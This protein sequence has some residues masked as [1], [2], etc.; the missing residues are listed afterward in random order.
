MPER[1]NRGLDEQL[2]V[3]VAQAAPKPVAPYG[4]GTETAGQ[5][6]VTA[7][8]NPDR[9][10]S[11]A[12]FSMLCGVSPRQVSSG[13]TKRHRLNRGGDRQ[14]KAAPYRIALIRMRWEE[15][16]QAYVA[17]VLRN[18]LLG[19][20]DRHGLREPSPLD[21]VFVVHGARQCEELE[22]ARSWFA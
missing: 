20:I 5:L 13:K 21:D 12:A 4:V 11:E 19:M 22:I 3:V 8:D 1:R 15:R 6:I 14:A 7:G 18:E 10:H 16:T 9:L 17:D 2:D